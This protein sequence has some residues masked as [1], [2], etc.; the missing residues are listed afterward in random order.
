MKAIVVY[1]TLYGNTEKI[2]MALAEGLSGSSVEVDCA[3]VKLVHASDLLAHELVAV[4]APTMAFTASKPMK[5]FFSSLK[6][7][8]L[9]GKMCFA[10]DTRIDNRLSGSA[11]K[12]IEGKLKEMGGTVVMPRAS[13]FIVGKGP[14]DAPG[15]T[16]L[17]PGMEDDFE[18]LG[19]KLGALAT[20]R[21]R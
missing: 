1:D 17:K 16:S 20:S 21:T 6:G 5:D 11:A 18:E 2:A 8:D 9:H 19:K 3:N 15:G 14:A 13:A 7:I 10:F 12:Y 4:G